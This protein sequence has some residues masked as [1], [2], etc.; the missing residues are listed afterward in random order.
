MK[1]F[2]VGECK[3]NIRK[4]QLESFLDDIY[5]RFYKKDRLKH[6]ANQDVRLPK[7]KIT[8]DIVSFSVY[9]KDPSGQEHKIII[10]GT[11]FLNE[12]HLDTFT[13]DHKELNHL[14]LNAYIDFFKSL[15]K[16]SSGY[17]MFSTNGKPARIK[18]GEL[19]NQKNLLKELYEK[20]PNEQKSE[21]QAVFDWLIDCSK[22]KV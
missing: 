13:L 9:F 16:V 3:L 10:D 6:I 2:L 1:R 22:S 12:I 4:E 5:Y 14:E 11:I 20:I 17:I 8:G 21:V 18:D 7:V 15:S 19:D